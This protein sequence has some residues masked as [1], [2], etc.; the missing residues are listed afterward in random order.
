MQPL[1]VLI[2][3][4][5]LALSACGGP[6]LVFPG[7]PLRGDEVG[8]IPDDWSF[9]DSSFMDLEVRPES[10]YSVTTPVTRSTKRHTALGRENP[11]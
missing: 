6:F 3:A 10:P 2:L 11:W 9:V 8:E 7:G 4:T 5:T 1:F